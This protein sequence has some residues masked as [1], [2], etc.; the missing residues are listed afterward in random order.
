MSTV[1]QGS[2]ES[3]V[4]EWSL[5]STVVEGSEESI[6]VE[7]SA[8][9]IAVEGSA[10]STVAEWSEES[11]A[12]QRSNSHAYCLSVCRSYVCC[13]RFASVRQTL[14]FLIQLSFLTHSA[15]LSLC[16]FK[17]ESV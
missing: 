17:V 3:T 7:G 9:S 6:G 10:E 15:L 2:A 8:E 14:P 4:V 12:V 13:L 5:G 1:V 11:I 16:W